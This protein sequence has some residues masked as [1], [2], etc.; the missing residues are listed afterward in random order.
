M[1]AAEVN[2]LEAIKALLAAGADPRITTDQGTTALMLAAGAARTS[3]GERLRN[4]R[5]RSRRQ[6]SSWNG[7]ST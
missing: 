7:A 1:L 5:W 3:K 4:R 6:S 2:N